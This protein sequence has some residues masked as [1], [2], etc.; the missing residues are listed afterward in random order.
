MKELLKIKVPL[1]PVSLNQWYAG[2]AH[3]SKRHKEKQKWNGYFELIKKQLMPIKKEDYPVVL[4][5]KVFFKDSRRRDTDNYGATAA[6]L[7]CDSLVKI[8]VL[9]D[10][11]Y[12]FISKHIYSIHP[13]PSNEDCVEIIIYSEEFKLS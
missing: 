3:W 6:K 1:K 11:N 4:E 5:V 8:G 9:S 7:T 10:D 2:S 13:E 12:K